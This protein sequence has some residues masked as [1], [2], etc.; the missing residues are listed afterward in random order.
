MSKTVRKEATNIAYF[1][2][3][4]S[5]RE[6]LDLC[7][8][9]KLAGF[10]ESKSGLWTF[11]E[12]EEGDF[13]SFLYGARVFHLYRVKAKKAF[14]NAHQLG[15]WKPITFR[16]GKTYS[17]PFRLFL[18][19][20]RELEEPMVRAEFAYV[21]ENLLLRG[22]YRKTHFQAD[23]T[24]LQA[25]SQMG[26]PCS[27]ETQIGTPGEETFIPRFTLK[28][29]HCFPETSPFQECFLQTLIRQWLSVPKNLQNVLE[30][31]NLGNLCAQDFEV[32]GEKALTTGHVDI[33]IKN[34]TPMGGSQKFVVEVKLNQARKKDVEQLM[35]YMH[36]IG[37]ECQGGILVA[38]GFPSSALQKMQENRIH[39]STYF[40][41]DLDPE[42]S[43]TFWE[44]R[45]KL[46]L[47][48]VS[49]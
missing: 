32:L 25:V 35:G 9:Y 23:Q 8:K 40:F 4:L 30:W 47:T 38:R 46:R 16:S 43:Y 2:L 11:T 44:F 5:N 31:C 33:L 28:G 17:F 20:S 10:T 36:E 27:E 1:L 24:T 21:A 41:E 49:S 45:S 7:L 26:V 19:L 37:K 3:A 39:A 48:R 6:N 18:S 12:I 42:K 13:V 22:G 34:R 29:P 14:R 15:P